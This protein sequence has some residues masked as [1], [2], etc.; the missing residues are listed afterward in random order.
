V[1]GVAPRWSRDSG[2]GVA[3]I[4]NRRLFGNGNIDGK[5]LTSVRLDDG[6]GPQELLTHEPSG[7]VVFRFIEE[8]FIASISEANSRTECCR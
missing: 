1:T 6:R 2:E 8:H 5:I 7:S 4:G 3:V